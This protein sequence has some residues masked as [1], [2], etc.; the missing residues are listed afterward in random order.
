M[1]CEVEITNLWARFDIDPE[2]IIDHNR[3]NGAPE[4]LLESFKF[5]IKT[6]FNPFEFN[7][8]TFSE[9]S[10]SQ[11]DVNMSGKS[12]SEF[13]AKHNINLDGETND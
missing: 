10:V 13:D 12:W 1:K 11:A 7:D 3:Q 5:A 4:H 2:Y 6:G 9:F 8:W